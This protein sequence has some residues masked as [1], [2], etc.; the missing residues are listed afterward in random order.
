MTIKSLY[1]DYF[2][3]S[4]VFLYPL[5]EIKRG[6]SVMPIQTYVSWEG[7]YVPEDRKLICLYHLRDDEE[8][9]RF[10]KQKLLGNHLFLD[11]K[12]VEDD[13][14]VYVFDLKKS[15]DDFDLFLQGRYS[16]MSAIHKKIV[17]SY[18]G[19]YS[20]NF[21]YVESFLNPEKY[22]AIYSEILGVDAE[23]LRKVGELCSLPDMEM[24]RLV[25][26][27]NELTLKLKTT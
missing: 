27:I 19:V 9:I 24:E 17:K 3:K 21:V 14:G 15:K 6:S 26:E 13:K 16:K 10:E 23:E 11:F 1:K 18:Y 20:S 2:Q 4:R 22:F 5:L 25:I 12:P 7:H 8:F